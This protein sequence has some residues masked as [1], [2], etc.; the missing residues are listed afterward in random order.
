MRSCTP[1]VANCPADWVLRGLDRR[2]NPWVLGAA[3]NAG[4]LRSSICRM[5]P[6]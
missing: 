6:K 4:F 1:L 5:S 3:V 2:A